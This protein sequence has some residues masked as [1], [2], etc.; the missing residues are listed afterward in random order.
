M[1]KQLTPTYLEFPA[2]KV[3]QPLGE[4][5]VISI[6]AKDLLS[7]SFSEPLKYI[8]NSGN[9]KGN[10][11]PKDEKR[12]KEIA[13]YIE[14]VEMAFPNS[15]ILT[16][17][18]TESGKILTD[19]TERWRI[20]E[21]ASNSY[22]LIIPKK[23][24][25]AAIIDGQHRLKAFDFVTKQERFDDLQLLC[26]V[27]FDLPSSYQAFLFATINSNQK[28][29][30]RSLAL[31]Q[32]GY[33][34]DD[35]T[36]KA[37][38]PEKL[39]VFL[40]RKLNTD[41]ITSPFY[42]HIKVAP[43]DATKLFSGNVQLSWVISTATIVDGICSLITSN[44]K[45]DRIL[46]QQQSVFSGRN[47][48]LVK[49]IKDVSP[50]R[51]LFLNLN[52][53]TLY[54]VIISF[55]TIIKN[56]LWENA[57]EKS[58]INKTVGVQACFDILKLILITE[59]S[60][61]P[62]QID[63]NL[64]ISKAAHIDFSDKFF[65]ASGIGRSRIKNTIGAATGLI[66]ESKLKKNDLTFYREILDGKNTDLVKEKMVWD[67]E[68][69]NAVLNTLEKAEWNFDSKSVGLYLSDDYS[70]EYITEFKNFSDFF[71]KL[72]EIAQIAYVSSLP[73]DY[74]F[75][76][77]Q[78]EKFDAEDLVYSYLADYDENLKKLGWYIN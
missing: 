40:S 42:T 24:K 31:E 45:R 11:R 25:L 32:F 59:K 56:I 58:Y 34:V 62:E 21:I 46:M 44:A 52:D 27:Y 1:D 38:T 75:A 69:E 7:I 54:D 33:N 64:Y 14:S 30:D 63:F 41:E 49:E 16:A 70:Y 65:Q 67:D 19:E 12:L 39:A 53:Q 77:E 6:G 66:H 28:K 76:E 8:D 43:M 35:E 23:I 22:K 26:S 72:L 36:E 5:Y 68:A 29:V 4:F 9:V 74:E 78:K 18:Y 20:E 57:S 51:N 3:N 61:H 10:Q 2:L 17:N 55:F 47:R 15:I 37:W 50:L 13:K 73:S 48:S 60:E 71:K